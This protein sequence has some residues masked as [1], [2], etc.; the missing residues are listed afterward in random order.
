MVSLSPSPDT[1]YDIRDCGSFTDEVEV[2]LD[3][4]KEPLGAAIKAVKQGIRSPHGFQAWFKY[5][6]ATPKVTEML[7]NIQSM[8]G[9]RRLIPYPNIWIRQPPVFVC[10]K[11]DTRERYGT[12]LRRDPYKVCQDTGVFG[13]YLTGWRYIFI[14][15]KFFTLR[16][17]PS[18]PPNR[19]CPHV[20]GNKFVGAEMGRLA[21]YR[22]YLL[23]HEM[24]HFYLGRESLGWGTTPKESYAWNVCVNFDMK[25]SLRNPMNFQYFVAMVEQQCTEA[26]NPFLPPFPL[27]PG[28][29]TDEEK[30]GISTGAL[31][32]SW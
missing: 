29:V 3:L 21:D 31:D 23:I 10:V 11:Q 20:T 14:C 22:T 27:P 15:E 19:Y 25:T 4:G 17:A 32:I 7:K 5:N 2:A 24:V 9:L 16:V 8:K 6:A 13:M 30:F 28:M 18:G 1:K 12:R 26:P